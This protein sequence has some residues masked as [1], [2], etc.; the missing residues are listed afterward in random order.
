MDDE[1]ESLGVNDP[2]RAIFK[3]VGHHE[4]PLHLEELVLAK[5]GTPVLQVNAEPL[6][7]RSGWIIGGLPVALLVLYALRT[8]TVPDTATPYYFDLV[9]VMGSS[10]FLT[11]I[12]SPWAIAALMIVTLFMLLDRLIGTRM[13]PEMVN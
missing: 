3:Q 7:S 10:Q 13:A 12:T 11:V 6:I 8:P 2:L 1:R 5:L 4:A 9:K